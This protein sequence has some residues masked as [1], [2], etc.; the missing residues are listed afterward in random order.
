MCVEGPYFRTDQIREAVERLKLE[1][2]T[3][4]TGLQAT[5]PIETDL[6]NLLA[7]PIIPLSQILGKRPSEVW[8]MFDDKVDAT[9]KDHEEF[10]TRSYRCL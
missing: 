9:V 10:R 5:V 8:A 6:I 7:Q 4:W 2:E 3:G 1:P